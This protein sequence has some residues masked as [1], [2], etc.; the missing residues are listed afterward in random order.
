MNG[1]I[2]NDWDPKSPV[3][4]ENQIA[5]YD[6]MRQRCPVAHS[7]YL[8]WSLFGHGDVMRVLEDPETFS[9]AVSPHLSIPNGMDPPVHTEYRQIVDKYFTPARMAT[10]EPEC[11]RIA[12]KLVKGLPAG[13]EVELMGTFALEFS[14]QMQS[15]FLG[16]PEHLHKP[17]LQWID[18]NHR[19]TLARDI[20]AMDAVA[21]EF[22]SFIKE[23]LDLRRVAGSAAP[24]D[25]TTSLLRD[26][27]GGQL[28]L[29]DEIVSILRNWTVAELST[30]AASVGILV[31]HLAAHPDI[32]RQLRA[33]PSSL[34]EAIDEMMRIH[35]AFISSR[36]ILT[37]PVEVGG[38]RLAAGD[39][40]T[41]IWASANRDEAVFG[42]P[43]EFRLDRDPASN[44]IYGAGVHICP[45]APLARLELRVLMEELLGH[46]DHFE[47]VTGS[48]PVMAAYPAGGFA[49]LPLRIG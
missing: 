24:D 7:D 40:I 18:K 1:R 16:W 31:G 39:R 15:E 26:T 27:V 45:G 20:P 47:L 44:L 29:D 11:R 30:I 35:A 3:V 22:D 12:I 48:E 41:L 38:H 2:G 10:F 8:N 9:N 17:L 46:T 36:R 33:E 43:D 25:I 42:D 6:N 4:L 19:A 28:L 37:K 13:V 14:L 23:L 32:Q 34:P 5:A 21:L 49:S